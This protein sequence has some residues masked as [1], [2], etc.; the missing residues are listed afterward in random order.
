MM[1]LHVVIAFALLIW[2]ARDLP[3]GPLITSTAGSWAVVLGQLFLAWL[4]ART[5]SSSAMRALANHRDGV[6][7]A[8]HCHHRNV[9]ILR[10][11]VLLTF[12]ADLMLTNWPAIINGQALLAKVPALSELIILS[13]F[14]AATV[15]VLWA[16]YPIDRALRRS[17]ADVSVWHGAGPQKVWGMRTYLDFN[18]RHQ[19]LTVL[20]PMT[21]ILIFVD[22]SYEYESEIV[23]AVPIPWLP[24]IILGMAAAGVFVIAPWFLKRI[25]TTE[26][27][28]DGPLRRNLETVCKRIGIKCRDILVWRSGGMFVNAAVMG[29]FA[30]VRYV[31]LSDGLLESMSDKQIE[32][33]F[34]HEAGHIRHRH[35]P[36]F[37]LFA[38]ASMLIASGLME[39]VFRWGMDGPGANRVSPFVIQL[40]GFAAVSAMWGFGFGFVS[41]RFERQAD[42][43]GARSVSPQE[44]ARCQVP[45]SMHP[46]EGESPGCSKS[47]CATGARIFVS[48]LDRV[49]LLNGIPLEEP[50]WRHSSIAHRIQF[51]EALSADPRRVVAFERMIR[52]IKLVLLGVCVV[53]LTVSA[54]YVWPYVS[55]TWRNG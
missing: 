19:L 25:W 10:G 17:I 2:W 5:A 52:I 42:L 9:M 26:R 14:L 30:R 53:G 8:Q 38:L 34:G 36:F 3:V 15:L 13:P 21:I 31:M 51:L 44:D 45:C 50:S 46:C 12:A 43:F 23:R 28:P 29:L 24:D 1:H 55:A 11:F 49:A 16:G 32:A 54:F 47:L 22:L 48:S 27:L 4:L 41:R 18:I 37:L 6:H 20:V 35:I 33:V 39:L 40:S 7:H